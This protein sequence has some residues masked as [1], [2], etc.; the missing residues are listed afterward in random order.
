MVVCMGPGRVGDAVACGSCPND[1]YDHDRD[2]DRASESFWVKRSAGSY[3]V[4][5]ET[6]A[7][8]GSKRSEDAWLR[9]WFEHCG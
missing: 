7:A 3:V 4:G 6:A 5:H 9:G 1:E 2:G 8:G